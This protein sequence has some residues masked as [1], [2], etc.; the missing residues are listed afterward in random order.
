M[1]A[2]RWPWCWPR[3]LA[4]TVHLL[5]TADEAAYVLREAAPGPG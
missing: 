1:T 5:L 3:P 4:G 2:R